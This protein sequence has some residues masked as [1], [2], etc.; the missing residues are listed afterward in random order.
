[1]KDTVLSNDGGRL[2]DMVDVSQKQR[3][4]IF[5]LHKCNTSK[6]R[7]H[8]FQSLKVIINH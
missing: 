4:R 6:T 2:G 1:M 8:Q 7:N 3:F 5:L